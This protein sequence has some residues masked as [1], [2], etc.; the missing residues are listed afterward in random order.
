MIYEAETEDDGKTDARSDAIEVFLYKEVLRRAQQAVADGEPI[1]EGLIK[2]A[3]RVLLSFGRGASKSPGQYKTDQNYVGDDRRKGHLFQAGQPTPAS[4][5]DANA[6]LE[7]IEGS[8]MLHL[9]K[10]GIAH[11]EFEALHPFN[12][13][14]G[15]IGRL[16]ITLLLWKY[17]LIH[18][19]HFYVSAFF[20]THK[21][22]YIELMRAVS[23]DD[24]WTSWTAFLSSRD[25]R[26][27]RKQSGHGS[28]SIMAL[29]EG[30]EGA[31][32][33]NFGIKVAYCCTGQHFREPGVQKQPV[34]S[35][36]PVCPSMWRHGSH[37]YSTKVVC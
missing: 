36:G 24:D 12:D 27:G 10:V 1:N 4:V 7:F 28:R 9:F 16:L 6:F 26:T 18:K 19:P 3:H 31:V 2:N 32:S 17:G 11:V 15:R 33:G 8:P 22:E 34:G 13:G 35:S 23:R 21:E 20:E 25:C 14:N 37:D 29:Y 30:Y 5:L